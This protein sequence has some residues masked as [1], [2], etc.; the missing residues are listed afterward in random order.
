MVRLRSRSEGLRARS[1]LVPPGKTLVCPINTAHRFTV[2]PATPQMFT[3][4]QKHFEGDSFCNGFPDDSGAKVGPHRGTVRSKLLSPTV[5]NGVTTIVVDVK[6]FFGVSYPVFVSHVAGKFSFLR[7]KTGNSFFQLKMEGEGGG[8]KRGLHPDL[9][10]WYE[11][12]P[13]VGAIVYECL[14]GKEGGDPAVCFN[15]P[16]NPPFAIKMLRQLA[17]LTLG[18]YQSTAETDKLTGWA[19]QVR[20][21][22]K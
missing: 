2:T 21:Y 7:T 10:V 18:P 5:V 19:I 22:V 9:F 13:A 20:G 17:R 11:A 14:V 16:D 3:N 4:Y 6:S 1:V 12:L 15:Q 8:T